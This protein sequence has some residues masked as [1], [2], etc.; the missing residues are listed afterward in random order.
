MAAAGCNVKICDIFVQDQLHLS[1]LLGVDAAHECNL[2][3]CS[4]LV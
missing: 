1:C 4:I 2:N 3:T